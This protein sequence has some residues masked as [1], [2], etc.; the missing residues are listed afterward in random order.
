[1]AAWLAAQEKKSAPGK[2]K[3]LQPQMTVEKGSYTAPA[4]KLGDN[5]DQSWSSTTMGAA[6]DAK[7]HRDCAQKCL[8]K[9]PAG[10]IVDAR[11]H[12]VY[13]DGRGAL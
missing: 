6:V 4:G 7:Q 3:I 5:P 8:R 9:G 10:R 12:A 13:V 2:S 11:Q 1:M